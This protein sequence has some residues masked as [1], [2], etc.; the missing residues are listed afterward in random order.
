MSQLNSKIEE[1]EITI[2][3]ARKVVEYGAV[4]RRLIENPDF[5]KVVTEGYFVEEGA[6][7][8]LLYSDPSM[9]SEQAR[10]I[11]NDLLG[12]GAFKRYIQVKL[13]MASSMAYEM[14]QQYETLEEL[15]EEELM[16][17]SE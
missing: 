16:G 2:A 4:V 17:E 9:S 10:M 8:A 11:N 14:E 5:N 13:Q 1:V 6:R 7:L 3:E 12:L 15:H